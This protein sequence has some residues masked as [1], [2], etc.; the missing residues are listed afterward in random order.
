M[1]VCQSDRL[2]SLAGDKDIG[3]SL[4]LARQNGVNWD[5]AGIRDGGPETGDGDWS[6]LG[7]RTLC[8]NNANYKD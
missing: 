8:V 5:W 6:G 7:R 3:S 4:L 2:V 1:S